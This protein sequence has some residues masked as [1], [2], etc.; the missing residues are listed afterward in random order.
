MHDLGLDPIPFFHPCYV[1]A[2]FQE[3]LW[4]E[5]IYR[6]PWARAMTTFDSD[7]IAKETRMFLLDG[8]LPLLTYFY[9]DGTKGVRVLKEQEGAGVKV[10]ALKPIT[11]TRSMATIVGLIFGLLERQC[12]LPLDRISKHHV[13][14]FFGLLRRLLHDWNKFEELL[15]AMRRNAIVSDIFDELKHLRKVC[16]RANAGGIVSTPKD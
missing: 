12:D 1:I 7:A 16:G 11:L 4:A 6:L 14:N 5:A 2:L 13:E 10:I 9:L 15:H 8:A 3:R